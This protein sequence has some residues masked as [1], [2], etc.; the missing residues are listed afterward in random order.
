MSFLNILTLFLIP[1]FF[2]TLIIQLLHLKNTSKKYFKAGLEKR[3]LYLFLL[4]SIILTLNL[5]CYRYFS[6]LYPLEKEQINNVLLS[7]ILIAICAN[8]IPVSYTHLTLPT[9]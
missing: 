8:L 7:S 3:A 5:L 4:I 1:F 2:Y 9:N 6:M